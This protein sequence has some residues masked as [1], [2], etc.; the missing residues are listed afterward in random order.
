MPLVYSHDV[1]P[2]SVSMLGYLA[3][4][5]SAM[6]VPTVVLVVAAAEVCSMLSSSRLPSSAQPAIPRVRLAREASTSFVMLV[7][8]ISTPSLCD[9][10]QAPDSRLTARSKSRGMRSLLA[11]DD[12]LAPEHTGRDFSFLTVEPES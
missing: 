1:F 6:D 3:I 12:T 11:V 10:L 4:I 2:V 5:Q 9:Q 8:T 7:F